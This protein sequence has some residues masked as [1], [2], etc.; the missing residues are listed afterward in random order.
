[1]INR[2]GS[3]QL[4]WV[5]LLLAI[6]V[7]L[8]TVCLLWFMSQAVKNVQIVTKQRLI[9]V[10][11]EKL[12]EAAEKACD[13]WKQE[14]SSLDETITSKKPFEVFGYLH[15]RLYYD[16]A[17]IYDKTGARIYPILSTDVNAIT[18]LSD[19]F[20]EAWK[21]EFEE[22]DYSKAVIL[23]DQ[24][25]KSDNIYI[26]FVAIL[27][28]SR[29]HAKLGRSDKLVRHSDKERELENAIGN[30]MQLAFNNEDERCDI[31]TLILL[32][33]ARLLMIELSDQRLRL[34]AH[35]KENYETLIWETYHHLYKLLFKENE[36][37]S[38]L[39]SDHAIF[40]ARR[41]LDI[42]KQHLFLQKHPDN[43]NF[44]AKMDEPGIQRR[45]AAEELSIRMVEHLPTATILSDWPKHQFQSIRKGQESIYA[46]R[47]VTEDVNIVLLC[48]E[49]SINWFRSFEDIFADSDAA[50][51]IIDDSGRFVTGITQPEGKPF[52]VDLVGEHFPGWKAELYF[53]HGDIFEEAEKKQRA[54]Y[55][56]AGTLMIVLML[57]AGGFASQAVGRQMKLNRLKNDFIATVSH[58]LKTPLASMR[59]LADTLLEGNYKDQKQATE[60]LH[61]ICKENKRLS[62]LIDNF[63]T[64]SR[65][66]RNKQAFE[67]VK[68]S[69]ASIAHAAADAVKTKF[70]KGRCD[71]KVEIGEDLPEVLADQDAMVTVLVNLLDNAYKYSSDE[72]HIE[73]RVYSGDDTV[74]FCVTDNGIGMS[75]RTVKK[76]FKRFYQVDRSLSRHTEGCGLGLSITKFIVDAHK[77]S[78]SVE[79]NPGKGSIFIVR[80]PIAK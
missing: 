68:T 38:F 50:Y 56:W 16:G 75:R 14:F 13:S 18:E 54:T 71:F 44:S 55:I 1:M 64:F 12:A 65:M 22:E 33:N 17:I 46:V 53:K 35:K 72:K 24:F 26:R 73:L 32:A 7:I 31:P 4:R 77:G 6:A 63:L 57:V 23:Y 20:A 8:P 15:D 74:C 9:K 60:Y 40:V 80:L 39:P 21:A 79:S 42:Y 62:G 47:H 78:I 76:I 27:C 25:T 58:E 49:K 52:G 69:P 51:R 5:I 48:K 28:Q 66:E 67:I 2:S 34:S 61:L 29:S 37:G 3:S 70:N 36:A 11:Q 30:C 59:I 45:I 19:I 10:Y 41:I 43:V